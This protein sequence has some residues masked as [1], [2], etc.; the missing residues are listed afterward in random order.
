MELF[1]WLLA[2]VLASLA[3]VFVLLAW[4]VLLMMAI[5]KWGKKNRLIFWFGIVP[6]ALFDFAV[7]VI[8]VTILTL[9]LPEELLVTRRLKRYRKL[10]DEGYMNLRFLNKIR[11]TVADYMCDEVL[12]PY[13]TITGDHC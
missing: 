12:D 5:K 8:P 2:L 1:L 9:N 6:F 7:N 4:F 10:I 3:C 13:D 11:L